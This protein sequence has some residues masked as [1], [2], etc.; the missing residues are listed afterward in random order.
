M[1]LMLGYVYC[2]FYLCVLYGVSDDEVIVSIYCIFKNDVVLEDIVVIIIEL[3][4]GEGGFYVVFLVF[5]QCLCV[6]CDEY[7]IMFIVDEVQ[8]GVG[9]IGILFVMEQMGVVVDIIIFVKFIVGG[10]LLVGVIG[11]VEVMDVIVFGGLG[12]I[13]VGNF[14]V[15]VV[16][17]VVL[18]IF[19]QE[20]LLEKVNQFGDILCQGLLVIVEDYLEIGDVCGLGVMIV[21]ELFEEGDC[22]RLNVRLMVDIV[23]CVCDKGLI[24]FF[25]GLYYNVLCILVL[26]IIEEVQIEQGFKII[27]DCFSEVK[28]VQNRIYVEVKY[29]CKGMKMRF[30]K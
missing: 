5:M 7:G 23:V 3:V 8:S 16:V 15:C 13:Y 1:G 11:C 21:I 2:V 26:L 12:G 4:Q 10:F 25:C 18:Q 17:L 24:L 27:V 28:Q 9:C 20:N 29:V 22:S 14:I 19:E 30:V 6:L